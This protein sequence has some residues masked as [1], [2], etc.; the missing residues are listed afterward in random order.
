MLF[1]E[2]CP[3]CNEKLQIHVERNSFI[4]YRCKIL[5]KNGIWTNPKGHVFSITYSDNKCRLLS[6]GYN[7]L[8]LDYLLPDSIMV[9]ISYSINNFSTYISLT[10]IDNPCVKH[11]VD[12]SVPE[13]LN[14]FNNKKYV[15]NLIKKHLMLV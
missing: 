10:K 7:N 4:T 6:F 13:I 5:S 15:S 14:P 2:N 8:E 3:I 1:S 11:I 12:F 9:D